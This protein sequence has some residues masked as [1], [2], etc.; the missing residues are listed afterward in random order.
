MGQSPQW[1]AATAPTANGEPAGKPK[2]DPN[3]LEPMAG[4]W[5]DGAHGWGLGCCHTGI[6]RGPGSDSGEVGAA[7]DDGAG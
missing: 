2:P 5:V 1:T 4:S 7:V 6:W 3:G